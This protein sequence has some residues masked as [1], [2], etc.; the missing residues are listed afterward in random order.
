MPH[1]LSLTAQQ[2]YATLQLMGIQVWVP[3]LSL[4]GAAPSPVCP[5][6]DK[7][8]AP[9]NKTVAIAPVATTPTQQ[10]RPESN[11]ASP[12]VSPPQALT[13]PS[14]SIAAPV[15]PAAAAS[16]VQPLEAEVW[17]LANG[18]Q[19]VLDKLPEPDMQPAAQQREAL[20]RLLHNL[21]K[22]LYPE[23]LGISSQ[24]VF[25]WPL[26]GVPLEA[27]HE[28][29]LSMALQAFLT[30]ARFQQVQLAGCLV[31]GERLGQLLPATQE[32]VRRFFAPNLVS[33]LNNPQAKQDFWQEAGT[34][35]LRA[36]FASA[37]L[38]V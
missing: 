18:W 8:A 9:S 15:Q 20:I 11:K 28:G 6:P 23:G 37:P 10:A 24:E 34:S 36:L 29:E 25:S 33:L 38:L 17:L 5:W 30:G 1:A 14:A 13:N 26:P 19:L 3:R 16:L 21:I 27:G 4:P 2:R 7:P 12:V 32:S 22:A 35:G 31:F